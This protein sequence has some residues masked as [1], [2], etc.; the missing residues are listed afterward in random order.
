[1]FRM[2]DTNILNMQST[3]PAASLV[4]VLGNAGI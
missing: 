2:L 1:M 4:K 3:K